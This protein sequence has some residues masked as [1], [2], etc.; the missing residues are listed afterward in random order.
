MILFS[1]NASG[2]LAASYSSG[3][4]ALTIG[5]G[6]GARFPAPSAGDYFYATVVDASNNIEIVKCTGRTADTLTVVRGQEGT[7][8]MALAS[9]LIIAVRLTTAGLEALRD[10]TV[11]T[12]RIEDSAVSTAKLA[13][14]A[15]STAKLGD[16]S[17]TP[18]KLADSAVTPAKAAAGLAVSNLGFTPV[19][20]GG[21]AGQDD[22]TLYL[23]WSTTL[24]KPKL[25]VDSTDLGNLLTEKAT[26]D[27]DSAGYRGAPQTVKNTNYTLE[28]TDAGRSLHH[29][30]TSDHIWTIPPNA[31]VAF[32]LGTIIV[33]TT[34]DHSAIVQT[35]VGV[36]LVWS[37]T[38]TT[39]QRILVAGGMAT[40]IKV[41][42]NKWFIAGAG[43]S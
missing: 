33:L 23:G 26:A 42:V 35:G 16:A 1:N 14:L 43:L 10:Q 2:T 29:N 11:A 41:G 3:A 13:N 17:V 38:N 4:T 25:Q 20:Q 30:D 6:Q 15:V 21:G 7:T 22:N 28:I 9:G 27:A 34:E 5:A 18:G 19:R 39:G 8:A 36:T 24:L 31:S 32:P 40:L 12:A 37:L